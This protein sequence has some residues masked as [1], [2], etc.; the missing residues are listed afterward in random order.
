MTRRAAVIAGLMMVLIGGPGAQSAVAADVVSAQE[1]PAAVE[2]SGGMEFGLPERTPPPR[3]LR[4]QWPVFMVLSL[5]WLAIVGYVL[6]FNGRLRRLEAAL[7]P[8]AGAA[9]EAERRP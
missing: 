1:A 9:T 5:F 4:D 8:V 3:T 2:Q 7:A 6:T